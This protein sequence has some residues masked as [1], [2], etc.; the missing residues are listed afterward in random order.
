MI[1]ERWKPVLVGELLQPS[2]WTSFPELALD[3]SKPL[4]DAWIFKAN[5]LFASPNFKISSK[6]APTGPWRILLRRKDGLWSIML[7]KIK[8]TKKLSKSAHTTKEELLK[9]LVTILG[10]MVPDSSWDQI[11]CMLMKDT[12]RLPKLR[13]MKLRKESPIEKSMRSVN[14]TIMKCM[15]GYTLRLP[16][17]SPSTHENQYNERRQDST[18]SWKEIAEREWK[19]DFEKEEKKWWDRF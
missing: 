16:K 6:S 8:T 19:R 1:W 18:K 10:S 17:N 9:M 14:P 2:V 11:P 12:P 13:S 15:I 4:T 3:K 7:S 5:L